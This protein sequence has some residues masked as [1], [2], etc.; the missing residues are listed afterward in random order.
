MVLYEND[1]HIIETTT[2]VSNNDIFCVL[3]ANA[4]IIEES[5]QNYSLTTILNKDYKKGLSSSIIDL[6]SRNLA[7]IDFN[8]NVSY[9]FK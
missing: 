3:G 1:K 8:H 5:I 9:V 7:N 6:V 2:E 4:T